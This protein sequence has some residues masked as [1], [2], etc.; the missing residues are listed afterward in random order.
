VGKVLAYNESYTCT[1]TEF[2]AGD[3]ESGVSHENT[4]SVT[5]SDNDGN[6]DEASDDATVDFTDVDPLID[7][8]KYV[9]VD[10]GLTWV[11]ADA[12]TG[13][14]ATEGDI[15]QFKLVVKNIGSVALGSVSLTDS[16]FGLGGCTIPSTLAA[17]A[18]FE[19]TVSTAAVTGQH[20]D[21]ATASGS[22]TDGAG[23]TETDTD[24]DDANYYGMNRGQPS[25]QINSLSI[26][27]NPTRTTVT[28]EFNITDESQSGNQPD[29]FLIALTN[30]GVRWETKTPKTAYVPVLPSGGCVYT[31]VS[32]DHPNP[33]WVDGDPIIFDESVTIGYT[34][35]FG[36]NQLPKGGTLR[37]TA[38]AGIFGRTGKEFTYSSSVP[39]PR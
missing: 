13:P 25:I 16:D 30:Y 31:I 28:G 34:C 14:F 8:E 5:G 12:T 11:D 21:T 3:Y 26:S 38:Y 4:A 22:I 35:T 6:S 10:G 29:G 36:G 15:V 24:T 18:S 9:S 23:N 32:V 20:T 17:G 19:C 7:V 1:F 2:V 39:I 27:I 37:G 33:G